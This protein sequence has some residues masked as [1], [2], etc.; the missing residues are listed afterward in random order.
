MISLRY[1]KRQI[2]NREPV[3]F[4]NQTSSQL[5]HQLSISLFRPIVVYDFRQEGILVS[6]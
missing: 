1:V 2:K 3:C 5:I 4:E 6:A